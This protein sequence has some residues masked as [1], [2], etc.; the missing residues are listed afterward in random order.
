MSLNAKKFLIAVLGAAFLA[1]LVFVQYMEV[2]RRAVEAGLKEEPVAVPAS[3]Q[4]CVECH[5]ESSPGIVGHW[6][7][8]THAKRGIGCF[9][10]HQ[11]DEGD[12]DAWAH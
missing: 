10:C 12:V 9:E 3:S 4:R 5:A 1:S 8:S 7:D 11:A 2:N 6:E